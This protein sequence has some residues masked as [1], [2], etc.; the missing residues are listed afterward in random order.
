MGSV[1]RR[2]D[3]HNYAATNV[4]EPAKYIRSGWP[5]IAK[6]QKDTGY[7]GAAD[8]V[9]RRHSDTRD[10]NL[11]SDKT[12]TCLAPH[13]PNMCSPQCKP[14]LY[15]AVSTH[16]G[17]NHQLVVGKLGSRSPDSGV[18]DTTGFRSRASDGLPMDTRRY[19]GFVEADAKP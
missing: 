7:M 16:S 10:M 14:T 11:R 2:A 1:Q 9:L 8:V 12:E 19:F 17:S 18:L 13:L 3:A 15:P 6:M 5:R 4:Q